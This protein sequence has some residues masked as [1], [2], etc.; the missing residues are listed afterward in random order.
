MKVAIKSFG[1]GAA[2]THLTHPSGYFQKMVPL[3]TGAART[4]T[5]VNAQPLPTGLEG[6]T[7][8]RTT[9]W[10]FRGREVTGLIGRST[11]A[12]GTSLPCSAPPR[13]IPREAPLSA[14]AVL[15]A[16]NRVLPGG[17]SV[18]GQQKQST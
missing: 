9:S 3:W 16:G 18:Q 14:R 5:T 10:F 12:P 4:G 11:G 15:V 13:G 7:L 17:S 1:S 6:P 2:A 8:R